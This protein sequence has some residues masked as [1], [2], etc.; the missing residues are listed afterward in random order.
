MFLFSEV[1]LVL[2]AAYL[3]LRF[4]PTWLTVP[5]EAGL[6]IACPVIILVEGFAA[7]T[8]ILSSGQL[9]SES[10][11]EQSAFVRAVVAAGCLALYGVSL[12][13]IGHLY[14]TGAIRTVLIATMIAVVLT[15]VFVLTAGTIL[16]PHGSI[17][18]S[19]LLMLY[20]TYNLWTISRRGS[21]I[22]IRSE[23]T[24][25]LLTFMSQS[26]WN[27]MPKEPLLGVIG[28]LLNMFSVELVTTILLQMAIFL[29]AAKLYR[30]AVGLEE[31]IGERPEASV[32]LLGVLWPCFGKAI[33][34]AVYTYAWLTYTR[35]AMLPLYLDPTMWRWM[36]IFGCILLYAYHLLWGGDQEDFNLH[37][38]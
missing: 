24:T 8:V 11:A 36:N 14:W 3:G 38:D 37:L 26:A 33:L 12:S 29:A 31:E 23:G 10:L 19:S 27:V 6:Q 28:G 4:L 2:V 30:R 17:T 15:L 7:M 13:V 5:Y 34:V 21:H 20:V 18:D 35:Q 22:A 16:A 25:S 9:W 32:W 1:P